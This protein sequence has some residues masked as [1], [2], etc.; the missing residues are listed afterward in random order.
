MRRRVSEPIEPSDCLV[1]NSHKAEKRV[2]SNAFCVFF[3]RF[4]LIGVNQASY[5]I[6]LKVSTLVTKRVRKN[7]AKPA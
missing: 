4:H 1:T 2:L 5:V 6:G 3:E 7:F